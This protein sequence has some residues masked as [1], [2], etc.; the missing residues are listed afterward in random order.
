MWPFNRKINNSERAREALKVMNIINP[1]TG[2]V[3]IASSMTV[4]DTVDQSRFTREERSTPAFHLKNIEDILESLRTSEAGVVESINFERERH[5]AEMIRLETNLANVLRTIAGYEAATLTL[6]GDNSVAAL[7]M[8]PAPVDPV[9]M[10]AVGEKIAA[11]KRT[12]R[13]PARPGRRETFEVPEGHEAVRDAEGRA[14]GEI[15][16]ID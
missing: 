13:R 4:T 16:P 3:N 11:T 9:R 2:L 14:T 8:T 7:S 10:T 1:K 12:T 15:R 5:A 6:R